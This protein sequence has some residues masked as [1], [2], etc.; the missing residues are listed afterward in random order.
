VDARLG[1]FARRAKRPAPLR[2][3]KAIVAWNAYMIAALAR[4]AIVIGDD[5]YAAAA[6][7]AAGVVAKSV[8]GGQPLP[9]AFLTGVPSGRGFLDDHTALALALLDLFE[10]TADP[11]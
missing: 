6:T 9:H 8:R 2:D 3:D 10:V 1:L 4:A 7:R 5:T 11:A